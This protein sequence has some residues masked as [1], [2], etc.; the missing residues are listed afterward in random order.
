MERQQ[1]V[2]ENT[3]TWDSSLHSQGIVCFA[4]LGSQSILLNFQLHSGP[5][6]FMATKLSYSLTITFILWL[7]I[8]YVNSWEVY[9]SALV[10][11][12]LPQSRIR[13]MSLNKFIE[14]WDHFKTSA[15]IEGKWQRSLWVKMYQ[16][17]GFNHP[18][19]LK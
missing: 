16:K 15:E 5:M 13:S 3:R 18:N 11:L 4:F 2:S 17:K 7:F 9:R 8:Q 10:M 19:N 14:L 6:P 1:L 12:W